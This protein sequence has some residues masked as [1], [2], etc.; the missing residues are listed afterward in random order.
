LLTVNCIDKGIEHFWFAKGKFALF[1]KEGNDEKRYICSLKYPFYAFY[2]NNVLP[3]ASTIQPG[4]W[5][6]SLS[7][8]L[9]FLRV[10]S[11]YLFYC[12]E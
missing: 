12:I 1:A 5:P 6:I 11:K 8:E 4:K 3:I 7:A 2:G 10:K 9:K